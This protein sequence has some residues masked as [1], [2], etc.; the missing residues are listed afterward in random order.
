[1]S[2]TIVAV[3][4]ANGKLIEPAWLAK[5]EVVHRQL[6]TALPM[7]YVAKMQRV[8]NDGG[9]M[10][11]AAEADAVR[12]VAVYRVYENTFDGV[13]LYVD[14]LVT[15]ETQRSRGVGRALLAHLEH[16]ARA[17]GCRALTLD[18]GVQRLQ[19]HK[20]YFREGMAIWSYHFAKPLT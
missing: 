12:G 2:F 4:D 6:R 20:F 14:D 16:T 5:A 17:L 3:T 1:M 7:D 15:D 10:V 11:L 19:A 13:Q 8:F 18:S 9:R